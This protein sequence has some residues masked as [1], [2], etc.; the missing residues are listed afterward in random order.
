[1]EELPLFSTQEKD[2]VLS[3][4]P[5]TDKKAPRSLRSRPLKSISGRTLWLQ[6][7]S[8]RLRAGELLLERLDSIQPGRRDCYEF[9]KLI[10]DIFL[11][12][13]CDNYGLLAPPYIQSKKEIRDGKTTKSSPRVDSLFPIVDPY[14]FLSGLAFQFRSVFFLIDSKN[15]SSAIDE[16]AVRQV[17][18][19]MSV[20]GRSTVG[21]ICAPTEPTECAESERRKLLG[22]GKLLVFVNF[23]DLK[24][25]I[26]ATMYPT[27]ISPDY[28]LGQKITKFLSLVR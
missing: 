9:E 5:Y 17:G 3:D 20:L 22:E 23:S 21:I 25:I 11:F 28:I 6:P 4:P 2:F 16:D 14:N 1:M 27:R 15:L 24:K 10:N 19:Y 18:A 13:F 7:D 26:K 8:L 12:A